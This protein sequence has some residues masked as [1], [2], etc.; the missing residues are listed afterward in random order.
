MSANF[1]VGV[2]PL[3]RD[4]EKQ[5]IAFIKENDGSWWHWI[6]NLWIARFPDEAEISLENLW[7]FL[8]KIS[9]DARIFIT[10]V[11]GDNWIVSNHELKGKSMSTWLNKHW[12]E[13]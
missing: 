12:T 13:Q 5:F 10:Q 7:H 11:E 4:Q 8:N 2:E 1:V 6:A 3:T 9:P